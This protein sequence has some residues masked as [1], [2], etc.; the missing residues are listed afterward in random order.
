[1]G[2]L[3]FDGSQF[4]SPVGHYTYLVAH[5]RWSWSDVV[6]EIHG[7]AP[8]AVAATTELMLQHTHPDDLAL[9]LEVVEKVITDGLPFSSYHRII[10][11][12]NHLR[13]VLFVGRGVKSPAGK[14]EEVTGFFVDL[15]AVRRAET[16]A[17]VDSALVQIAQT[18]SVI[19][20]AKGMLMVATGCDAEGAFE[21][22]RKYS[23]HK[24]VKLNNLAGRL[25][26]AVVSQPHQED[27]TLGQTVMKFLD[28]VEDFS[29]RSAS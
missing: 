11:A 6:Y 29:H 15:T 25:V 24:N 19:D 5:D 7:Y 17:E 12:K 18:R 23:S 2:V 14:V 20:Q 21:I 27:H 4:G 16:Q 10:D 9:A 8:H 22:L 28:D 1:M 13:W 26:D 3:A